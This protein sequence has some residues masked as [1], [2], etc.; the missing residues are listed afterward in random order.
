MDIIIPAKFYNSIIGTK[1]RL[2]RSIKEDCG[3]VTIQFPAEGSGS[4]KVTIRGPKEDVD[5]AK[6]ILVELSN[7]KQI[8][9]FTEEV[10]AKK[11]HHKF[12]IGKNGAN[13]KK[14]RILLVILTW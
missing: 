7:E 12:L 4:D 9:G 14:V 11:E 6:K 13:I 3:G 8:S 2:I 5:K 10:R 1:G